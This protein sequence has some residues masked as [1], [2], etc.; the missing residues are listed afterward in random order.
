M[1][2]EQLHEVENLI[3]AQKTDQTCFREKTL[4]QGQNSSY[5]AFFLRNDYIPGDSTQ[6]FATWDDGEA[7]GLCHL[8]GQGRVLT[9]GTCFFQKYFVDQDLIY[10]MKC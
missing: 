10:S 3:G 1:L 8:L 5:E 2:R 4:I 9:L 6:V 7:A